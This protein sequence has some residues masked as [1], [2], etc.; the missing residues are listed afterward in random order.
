MR[1]GPAG[2]PTRTAP[3]RRLAD[4]RDDRRQC[5]PGVEPHPEFRRRRS[6]RLAPRPDAGLEGG[7]GRQVQSR[8]AA[9]P[10]AAPRPPRRQ[11][12][13]RAGAGADQALSLRPPRSGGAPGE[14]R[15]VRDRGDGAGLPR[16]RR[17]RWSSRRW[18]M[19]D[20]VVVGCVAVTRVRRA[21][22]QGRR[23]R[24]PRARH[25]PRARQGRTGDTPIATTV[26]SSQVVD[27]ARL[28][29]MG[30]DSALHFI[31]TEKELIETRD[32]VR[33]AGRASTGSASSP[34]ST[35]TSRSSRSS[36]R[37]SPGER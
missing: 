33:P 6:R 24:R 27:D 28:P 8:S 35:R 18:S 15:R 10:G 25:L 37:G 23:L 4:A 7:A 13:L 2:T 9:D 12:R 17:S 22:R 16:R 20:F 29:M 11:D 31:A 14:G 19:L 5:R 30:H 36:A 32:A 1:A 3:R 21:D 26:H 34:T